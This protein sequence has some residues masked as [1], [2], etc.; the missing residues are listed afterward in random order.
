VNVVLDKRREN[1]RGK[2]LQI[3]ITHKNE[4]IIITHKN[5]PTEKKWPDKWI[6]LII[7]I[8]II[9]VNSISFTTHSSPNCNEF[10][11]NL[12]NKSTHW[13]DVFQISHVHENEADKIYLSYMEK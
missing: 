10:V 4:Q 8:I 6:A 5:E 3:I 9:I 11:T 13:M 2:T 7:I 12:S 1:V